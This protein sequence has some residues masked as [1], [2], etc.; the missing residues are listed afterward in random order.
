[1]IEGY[2]HCNTVECRNTAFSMVEED[3][4]IG[5]TDSDDEPFIIPF[6]AHLDR[7]A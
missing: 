4:I 2:T 3:R 1:M 5:L 7:G 6:P